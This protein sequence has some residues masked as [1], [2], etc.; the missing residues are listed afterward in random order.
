MR[1]F[2]HRPEWKE[3]RDEILE[4]D[5]WICLHCGRGR[6]SNSVLQVHH[7]EYLPG[8]LP[9]DHP[10]E[11]CVTLCKG[12]HAVE[13]GKIFPWSG[14]DLVCD[15]DLGDLTGECDL[16]LTALRYEF[17]IEHPKWFPMVVGTDCCDRLTESN[18]ASQI[19]REKDRLKRFIAS[20]RWNPTAQ[21]GF[22]IRKM[23]MDFAI[24][25]DPFGYRIV[26]TGK[27]GK[28][29]Y[30]TIDEA[31]AGLFEFIESGKA[32]EYLKKQTNK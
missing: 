8:L 23:K 31:K 7:M 12:C 3:F 4:R 18:A 6:H 32:A 16:C 27:R 1:H 28:K 20:P 22:E 25:H 15:E 26:F 10:P 29:P 17:H 30:S 11:V 21:N 19:R 13:H 2:Y 24:E 5:G 14:W 9:W